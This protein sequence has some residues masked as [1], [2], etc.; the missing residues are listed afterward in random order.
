MMLLLVA[1]RRAATRIGV[2]TRRDSMWSELVQLV[3]KH[4]REDRQPRALHARSLVALYGA[5]SNCE[6]AFDRL[7]RNG[8]ADDEADAVLA[9]DVVF[10]TL[11]NVQPVLRLFEPAL[12]CELTEYIRDVERSG[13]TGTPKSQ[14]KLQVETLRRLLALEASGNA[15][16]PTSSAFSGARR[17]L[18][19]FIRDR[20]A[21]DELFVA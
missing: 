5:L 10:A 18:A 19:G 2:C 20:F 14:L 3:E 6:I 13:F 8:A 4:C 15:L 11:H 21:A 7:E 12:A 9:M 16:E 17:R 1:W